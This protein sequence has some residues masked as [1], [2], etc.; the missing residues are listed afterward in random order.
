MASM[1]E[2]AGRTVGRTQN[3]SVGKTAYEID[4]LQPAFPLDYFGLRDL[5]LKIANLE[6]DAREPALCAASSAVRGSLAPL[7]LNRIA[8][9]GN[10][11]GHAWPRVPNDGERNL[12]G[13]RNGR[14]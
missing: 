2:G 14:D 7:R 5:G 4:Q 8:K 3:R 12:H 6:W 11:L 9:A 10:A 1:H 13:A